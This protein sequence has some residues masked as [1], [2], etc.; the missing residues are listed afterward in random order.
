MP[1]HRVVSLISGTLGLCRTVSC[2]KRPIWWPMKFYKQNKYKHSLKWN[3]HVCFSGNFSLCDSGDYLIL[4]K[5]ADE[6][7]FICLCVYVSFLEKINSYVS[8]I[9]MRWDEIQMR[10]DI[11]MRWGMFR[12]GFLYLY[13]LFWHLFRGARNGMLPPLERVGTADALISLRERNKSPVSN[14]NFQR[15]YLPY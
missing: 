13:S 1:T 12:L 11:P 14:E 15:S 3:I 10:W 4:L 5:G 9:P 2:L 8:C 7:V 6:F